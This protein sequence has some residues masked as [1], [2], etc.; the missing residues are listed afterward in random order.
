M[1]ARALVD[2]FDGVREYSAGDVLEGD[3]Q[4]LRRLLFNNLADPLDDDAK[5]VA[6]EADSL[7]E[8]GWASHPLASEPHWDRGD[9]ARAALGQA[10]RAPSPKPIRQ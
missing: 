6:D 1:K 8:E 10:A 4:H 2:G 7:S 9:E 3:S 5:K